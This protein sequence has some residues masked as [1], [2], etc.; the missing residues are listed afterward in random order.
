MR[1]K[2]SIVICTYNGEKYIKEV[3]KAI[4]RQEDYDLLLEEIIVVDNASTDAT[5]EIVLEFAKKN[6]KIKYIYEGNKGLSHARKHATKSKGEWVIFLDDDNIIEIGW[7]KKAKEYIE[8]NLNIGIFGG[9]SIAKLESECTLDEWENLQAIFGALACTHSC[10]EALACGVPS[11]TNGEIFGAGMV[12]KTAALKK[13]LED[14]WTKNIGRCG[15]NLGAYEDTEIV[16]G[17][18]KQGYEQGQNLDM[19]L[20]HIIPKF[21]LQNSYI[22]KLRWGIRESY[23]RYKMDQKGFILY[24]TKSLIKSFIR[25]IRYYL[26]YIMLN[27]G[28]S[29][30]IYYYN[31]DCEVKDI[32]NYCVNI[33]EHLKNRRVIR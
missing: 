3:M 15:N 19:Y 11:I 28:I 16:R 25:L 13:L 10:L 20:Y 22:K 29:K 17:V 31:V 5:K 12:V 2:F 21:R 4:G 23:Y 33:I 32:Q 8:N 1:S 18:V 14:G 24:R 27:D 6:E 26:I 9:A 30:K 7:L